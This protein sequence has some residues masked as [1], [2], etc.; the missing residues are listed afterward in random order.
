MDNKLTKAKEILHHYNQE[1]LL[2]FYD[3][4]S[5]EQKELLLNQILGI[6]FNKILTLYKNS[7]KSTKLDLNT[8]SPLPHIEKR[9][10]F[11]RRF[12]TLH[13]YWRKHN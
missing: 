5:E 10:N 2:Y 9:Q 7:F 3:E 4:L 13:S 6:D 11:K 8:V 12:R 1:H